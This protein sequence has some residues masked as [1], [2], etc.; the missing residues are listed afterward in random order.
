VKEGEEVGRKTEQQETGG[1][2]TKGDRKKEI[3]TG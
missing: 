3:E 2:E 1:Q